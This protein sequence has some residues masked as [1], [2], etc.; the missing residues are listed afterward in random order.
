MVPPAARCIAV[1]GGSFDP[2]HNGHVLLAEHFAV[3]AAR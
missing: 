1:L 3:A 2:V